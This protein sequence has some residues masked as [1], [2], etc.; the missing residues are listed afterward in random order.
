MSNQKAKDVAAKLQTDFN[1]EVWDKAGKIA[2]SMD[3]DCYVP[4]TDS[5]K[6]VCTTIEEIFKTCVQSLAVILPNNFQTTQVF[7]ALE[8]AAMWA[9]KGIFI[10]DKLTIKNEASKNGTALN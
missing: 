7:V 4:L 8:Q 1:K 6:Q 10:H 2:D 3:F 5:A 9:N